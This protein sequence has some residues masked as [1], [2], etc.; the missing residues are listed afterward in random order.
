MKEK[1]NIPYDELPK[2]LRKR[3]EKRKSKREEL[4]GLR[5]LKINLDLPHDVLVEKYR[6]IYTDMED[7]KLN[8]YVKYQ[9]MIHDAKSRHKLK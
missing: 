3:I 7:E 2:K 5:K 8:N 6:L 4:K 1:L 9:K